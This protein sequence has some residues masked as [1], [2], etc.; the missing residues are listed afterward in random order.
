M[1]NRNC[2]LLRS[3]L[4]RFSAS[5]WSNGPKIQAFC[6]QCN[7]HPF[8]TPVCTTALADGFTE[9]L[10]TTLT[11]GNKLTAEIISRFKMRMTDPD[12]N[13]LREAESGTL[14][15]RYQQKQPHHCIDYFSGIS[16]RDRILACGTR[17]ADLVWQFWL[18]NGQGT[19]QGVSDPRITFA[20][21]LNTFKER[22]M[23]FLRK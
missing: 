18:L 21:T 20:E 5:W 1:H 2:V 7:I 12:W 8:P 15:I 13:I 17:E 11:L 19:G 16:S 14:R 4:P 22:E 10:F 9:V 3:W 6:F 23:C